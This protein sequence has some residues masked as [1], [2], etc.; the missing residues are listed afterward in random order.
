MLRRHGRYLL[1]HIPM[2]T[3]A[4]H[5][6]IVAVWLVVAPAVVPKTQIL[7][8]GVQYLVLARTGPAHLTISRIISRIAISSAHNF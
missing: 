2:N 3:I 4:L 7:Q 8:E 6:G 5:T 1:Y